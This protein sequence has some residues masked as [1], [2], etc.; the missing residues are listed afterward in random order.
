MVKRKNI[1]TRLFSLITYKEQN[2]PKEFFI[3]EVNRA[4]DNTHENTWQTNHSDDK[5]K[6]RGKGIKKPIPASDFKKVKENEE[7]TQR[8]GTSIT[9]DENINFLSK[10]DPVKMLG[11]IH[12][13]AVS[14][15]A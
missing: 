7:K 3:P 15:A 4:E 12:R 6:R 14:N 9:I 8:E 13:D 11:D 5:E 2:R 10:Y 1:L